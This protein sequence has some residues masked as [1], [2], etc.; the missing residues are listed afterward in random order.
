MGEDV[1]PGPFDRFDRAVVYK[2][3]SPPGPSR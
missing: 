2:Y 3:L 1:E